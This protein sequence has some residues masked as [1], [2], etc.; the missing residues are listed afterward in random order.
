LTELELCEGVVEIGEESF[1]GCGRSITKII[2]PTSLR[3]MLMK[4]SFPFVSTMALKALEDSHS[5]AAYLPT[6]E[7]HPSSL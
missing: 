3:R 5:M 7:P 4:P 1:S 2:I 6:L